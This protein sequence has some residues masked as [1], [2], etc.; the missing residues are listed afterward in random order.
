MTHKEKL[1]HQLKD[2]AF[3]MAT[4]SLY[5]YIKNIMYRASWY[6]QTAL[7]D[8]EVL[9]LRKEVKKEARH[10]YSTTLDIKN[11][12]KWFSGKN[13]LGYPTLTHAT[14]NGKYVGWIENT[15]SRN[16]LTLPIIQVGTDVQKNIPLLI[17]T[18]K[19]TILADFGTALGGT[20]VMFHD[21]MSRYC[22]P[23]ILSIDIDH[24]NMM[25]YKAFHGANKSFDK[26]TFLEKDSLKCVPEL[27]TF[28]S[29]RTDKDR[30]LISFDD[31]HTF[32]HTY[33]Q[34][35]LYVPLLKKGDV[36]V[37][38]DTWD[39][40]LYNHEESPMLA[41]HKYLKHFKDLELDEQFSKKLTLPSNFIYGVLIKK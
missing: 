1:V 26:M 25:K 11:P 3:I 23:Q 16:G 37:M 27:T 33:Q 31:N 8:R 19:P 28:L 14:L 40:D 15:I 7:F 36:V 22:K 32:K 39:Q 35:C 10:R 9:T 41:V 34:L 18:Y 29:K 4:Y 13:V 38:Q 2:V 12:R 20:A 21:L 24:S 30:V 17:E 5:R 6:V